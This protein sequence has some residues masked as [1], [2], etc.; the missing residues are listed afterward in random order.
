MAGTSAR[1]GRRALGGVCLVGVATAIGW[2]ATANAAGA[3]TSGV[4][5][6]VFPTVP[7]VRQPATLQLWPFRDPGGEKRP[8]VLS[9]STNL[10]VLLAS[11]RSGRT[12]IVVHPSRSREDPYRWSAVF[13]FPAPGHWMVRVQGYARAAIGVDVAPRSRPDGTWNRLERPL[14]MPTI[15]PGRTCPVSQSNPAHDLGPFG[16]S[17]EPAWGSGPAYPAL[18]HG[19]EP[20]L[21]YEYPAAPG[22][23]FYGMKWSG[24]KTVWFFDRGLYRGPLL[25]RGMQLDGIRELRFGLG[26]SPPRA[27]R[28]GSSTPVAMAYTR[29]AGPGGCYGFQIDGRSFTSTVIFHAISQRPKG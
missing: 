4:L 19:A 26:A 3:R 2:L 27:L 20:A 13:R 9:S 22:S 12:S 1:S 10:K 25:I 15:A 28:V 6:D 14:R 24:N 5:V 18:G 7:G 17:G 29:I 8:I 11:V 16:D 21:S 23:L